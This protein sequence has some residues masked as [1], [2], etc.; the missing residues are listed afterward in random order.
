MDK[1]EQNGNED[2]EEVKAREEN[3]AS[4]ERPN[5]EGACDEV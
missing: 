2:E 4:I 5:Y 1:Y 3:V